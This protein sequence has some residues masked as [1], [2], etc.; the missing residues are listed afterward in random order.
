MRVKKNQ[1]DCF[2]HPTQSVPAMNKILKEVLISLGA[3][4]VVL[5]ALAVYITFAFDPN[6]YKPQI[7]QLVKDKTQRTLQLGAIKLSFF[8]SIGVKVA[9]VSL[10]EYKSDKESVAVE[11]G[12][13][14]LKL[15]PLFS[16]QVVVDEIELRGVHVNLRRFKDGT[17]NMSDLLGAPEKSTPQ[18]TPV[19]PGKPGQLRFDIDHV[20]IEDTTVNYYDEKTGAKYVLS[21]LNLKTGRIANAVPFNVELGFD[22]LGNR[23]AFDLNTH[24]K[25]RLTFDLN[26]Q[27]Y[28]LQALTLAVKGQAAGISE[29]VVNASGDVS[30]KLQSK[31]FAA[32]KFKLEAT[33]VRDK[34]NLD[35]KLETPRLRLL[36]EKYSGDKVAVVAKMT[37][38]ET[39]L[40][41]SLAI[42]GL[43]GTSRA[44]KV[45]TINLQ[46]DAK[47]GQR[48]V[49]GRLTTPI[50][51]NIET[52]QFNF[53]NITGSFSL[54]A[55][56]LAVKN[57]SGA[58][59]G[60]AM[61]D[62]EKQNIQSNFSGKLGD[63]SL[64]AKIG[65]VGFSNP[66]IGFDLDVDRLDVDRYLPPKQAAQAPEAAQAE[67]KQPEKRLDFSALKNVNANGS[68]R[69]GNLK[70]A[71]LKAEQVRADI[72][73]AGGKLD[74]SPLSANLYQGTAE[75]NLGINA[76]KTPV[77]SVKQNLKG[78][79]IGPLLK[80]ATGN[81]MLEGKGIASL[82]VTTRGDTVTAMK[83][84][85]DGKAALN[86]TD[87][88][89]KGI[90]IAQTLREFKAKLGVLKGQQTEVA[91]KTRKTDF[92]EL[93]ASFVIKNGV[94]HNDDLSMKSPL[95]RLT[96]AGDINIGEDSLNYLAKAS[97]VESSKGQGGAEMA[98]LKGVTIPVRISG[99]LKSPQYSLDFS[100][101][102]TEA[103]KKKADQ[104]VK[105]GLQNPLKNIFK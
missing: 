80:D 20:S 54:S 95:L 59:K 62:L 97:V 41:A 38:A 13:V 82:D 96:G 65:V 36:N 7:V 92:T 47:Q 83:K 55:P 85:L 18:G 2:I 8:P 76:L 9:A 66:A 14:S 69:V 50:S 72:K 42:P 81:D 29:L 34:N 63:S 15:L 35:V 11:G 43:E 46:V 104:A 33:G 94:A 23:P 88:A 21:R 84:G 31:E 37:G 17:T 101:A 24:L 48:A 1:Y 56:D 74:I 49:K 68:L 93:K 32:D 6:K 45:G 30:A 86:L 75:G 16:E 44:F 26:K 12:R 58:L 105:K 78:V 57:L 98:S 4:V 53:P 39:E 10:S 79:N 52:Q 103:V 67:T 87:G 40:A 71:N 102:V 19:E 70:V 99:P 89:L 64:K 73:A 77:V 91:D 25:T 90:N 5:I 27:Q 100:G 28:L 3:L 61:A 22:V 60:S 51:G